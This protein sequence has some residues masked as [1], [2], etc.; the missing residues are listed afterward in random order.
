MGV[1]SGGIAPCVFSLDTRLRWRVCF[2]ARP[3][4]HAENPQYPLGRRLGGFQSRS[5]TLWR[6]EKN[7]LFISRIEPRF[8]GSL[9]CNLVGIPNELFRLEVN[10]ILNSIL[11][12]FFCKIILKFWNISHS[13]VGECKVITSREQLMKLKGL[14]ECEH[15]GYVIY[16]MALDV[17]ALIGMTKE[18]MNTY[19]HYERIHMTQYVSV[20]LSIIRYVPCLTNQYFKLN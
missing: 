8:V 11:K 6:R 14:Q 20:V 15:T 9:V 7:M 5:W 18:F 16:L 3:L 1:G 19:C 17:N 2:T 12:L 4:F 10:L 13:D